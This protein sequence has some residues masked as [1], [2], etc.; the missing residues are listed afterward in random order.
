MRWIAIEG[1]LEEGETFDVV[2]QKGDIEVTYTFKVLKNP[3]RA[4]WSSIYARRGDEFVWPP[5]S[6]PSDVQEEAD[7][8][9]I[10]LFPQ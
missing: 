3:F 2:R 4:A 1:A 9:A 7:R 10:E 6:V 5:R 8:R